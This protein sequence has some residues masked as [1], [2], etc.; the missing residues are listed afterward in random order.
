MIPRFDLVVRRGQI[1]LA[2][3]GCRAEPGS[4]GWVRRDPAGQ[5]QRLAL[6]S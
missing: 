1:V 6:P 4:G 2:D 3:G 5:C